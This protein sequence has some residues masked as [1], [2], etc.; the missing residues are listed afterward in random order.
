MKGPRAKGCGRPPPNPDPHHHVSADRISRRPLGPPTRSGPRQGSD[1]RSR[2]FGARL[3][4]TP[5]ASQL[6][7]AM[8][9][10]RAGSPSPT[11]DP[12]RAPRGSVPDGPTRLRPRD[13]SRTGGPWALAAAEA[14]ARAARMGGGTRLPRPPL[15]RGRRRICVNLDASLR[16]GPPLTRRVAGERG[17]PPR[18]RS[19]LKAVG[20]RVRAGRARGHRC[21][22]R[23]ASHILGRPGPVWA[24]TRPLPSRP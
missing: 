14:L 7:T 18:A 5:R 11:A 15:V 19:P 1:G 9:Q 8:K 12:A 24:S 17:P 21:R 16:L 20:L 23:L 3:R 13:P 2:W 10:E 6:K 4:G 22:E